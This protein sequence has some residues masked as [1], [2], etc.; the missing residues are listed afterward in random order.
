M[1][2]VKSEQSSPDQPLLQMH[3]AV[4]SQRPFPEQSYGHGAGGA[5][6]GQVVRAGGHAM[7]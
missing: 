2:Q 6:S 7:L 3:P 1:L 5:A 4:T